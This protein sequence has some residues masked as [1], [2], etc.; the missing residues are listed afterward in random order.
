MTRMRFGH[1]ILWP[2]AALLVGL[3]VG[4][5]LP[6]RPIDAVATDSNDAF[7]IATAPLNES[8][9]GLYTLDNLTGNLMVTVVGR[10][11]DFVGLYRHNVMN[12]LQIDPAK[13]PRFLMVPGGIQIQQGATAAVRM[14]PGLSVIYVAEITTGRA[15]AYVTYWDANAWKAGGQV[16]MTLQLVGRMPIRQVVARPGT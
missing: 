7:S 11:G 4:G 10:R 14:Q 2:A 5:M 8:V 15:A 16:N 13:K 12:D 9:E 1:L 3:I 6:H